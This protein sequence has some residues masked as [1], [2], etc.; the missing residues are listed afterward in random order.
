S[1]ARQKSVTLQTESPRRSKLAFRATWRHRDSRLTHAARNAPVDN[2]YLARYRLSPAKCDDLIGDVLGASCSAEY[3]LAPN[4]LL[5]LLGDVLGHA[6]SFNQTRRDA[7]DCY[8]WRHCNRQTV[9]EVNQS[10]LARRVRNA[11]AC[12]DESRE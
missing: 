9:R 5:Y 2:N 12:R 3:R 6:R 8:I 7:V 4:L 10:C 11:A 1:L